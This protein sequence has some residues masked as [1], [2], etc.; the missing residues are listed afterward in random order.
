MKIH[1]DT[2]RSPHQFQ[3]GEQA[4]LKLQPYAQ[5]SVVNKPCPKLALKYFGPYR[6]L[7]RIWL[8]GIQNSVASRFLGALGF[9]CFTIEAVY[10]E[11]YSCIL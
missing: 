6:A 10:T 3:V 11:L 7:D 1:A 9:S 4:L 2:K 8:E 5:S